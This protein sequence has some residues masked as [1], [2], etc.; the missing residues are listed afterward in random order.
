MI[1]VCCLCGNVMR[2]TS[3]PPTTAISH[4]YCAECAK[5]EIEK[6]EEAKHGETPAATTPR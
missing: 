4:G 3:V 2:T 6:L 5:K 1:H